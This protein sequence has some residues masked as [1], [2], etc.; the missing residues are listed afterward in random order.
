MKSQYSGALGSRIDFK[1]QRDGS[2]QVHR[3]S[4]LAGG[5]GDA[6]VC[7][8]GKTS[9]PLP[10][11][12]AF[13]STYLSDHVQPTERMQLR[14]QTWMKRLVERPVTELS[15]PASRLVVPPQPCGPTLHG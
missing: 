7:T 9:W 11:A 4:V 5:P 3:Y 6:H 15:V 14:T 2:M 12:P 10:L 1:L 13:S 8:V